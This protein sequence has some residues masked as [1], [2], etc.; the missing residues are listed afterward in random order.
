M[1][2][3]PSDDTI[4]VVGADPNKQVGER[5]FQLTEDF[6]FDMAFCAHGGC[7]TKDNKSK[8]YQFPRVYFHEF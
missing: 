7:I 8:C 5:E 1:Y 6:G 2:K 4:T 3:N